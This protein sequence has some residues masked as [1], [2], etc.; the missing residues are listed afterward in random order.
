MVQAQ[1]RVWLLINI[2][3]TG[4]ECVQPIA[5]QVTNAWSATAAQSAACAVMV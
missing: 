4:V 3:W 2:Y 5:N 1:A